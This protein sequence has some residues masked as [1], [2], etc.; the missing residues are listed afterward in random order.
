MADLVLNDANVYAVYVGDIFIYMNGHAVEPLS[1][2]LIPWGYGDAPWYP[3]YLIDM[4]LVV[5]LDYWINNDLGI[6]HPPYE[7]LG[8]SDNEGGYY[9]RIGGPGDFSSSGTGGTILDEKLGM[10]DKLIYPAIENTQILALYGPPDGK[11]ALVPGTGDKT[12]LYPPEEG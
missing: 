2:L 7:A 5:K 3:T 11:Y 12:I 10:L 8:T 9:N 1:V 6:V 4:R